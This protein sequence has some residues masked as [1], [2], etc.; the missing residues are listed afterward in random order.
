[1]MKTSGEVV[2]PQLGRNEPLLARPMGERATDTITASG[3]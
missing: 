1:M 3:M 2:G